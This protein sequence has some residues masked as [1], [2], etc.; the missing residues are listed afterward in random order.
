[1]NQPLE[2]TRTTLA[3]Q[4]DLLR[5]SGFDR[6]LEQIR[7]HLDSGT[8]GKLRILLCGSS[9][10]CLL[11]GFPVFSKILFHFIM[12]VY[13]GLLRYLAQM[14]SSVSKITCFTA[15]VGRACNS[16]LKT[17]VQRRAFKGT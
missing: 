3:S 11:T 12:H 14:N 16:R 13:S 10:W 8:Q 9:N 1:M 7:A 4:A 15:A 17:K 5:Q 2:L 6:D